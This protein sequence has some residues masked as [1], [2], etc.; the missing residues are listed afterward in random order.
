MIYTSTTKSE[1]AIDEEGLFFVSACIHLFGPRLLK[2]G[3]IKST[4]KPIKF[5]L[6]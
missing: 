3:V 2:N 6:K 1:R 5:E 4:L